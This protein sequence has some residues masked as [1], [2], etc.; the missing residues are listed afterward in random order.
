MGN[1]Q[2]RAQRVTDRMAD[3]SAAEVQGFTRLKRPPLGQAR[4]VPPS[5]ERRRA[6]H[7]GAQS[8]WRRRPHPRASDCCRWRFRGRGRRHRSRKRPGSALVRS[9][10]VRATTGCRRLQLLPPE[11][12]LGPWAVDAMAVRRLRPGARGRRDQH[13]RHRSA[14]VLNRRKG[15]SGLVRRDGDGSSK[16]GTVHG[17]ATAD[18]NDDRVGNGAD[19]MASASTCPTCPR[20]GGRG[21]QRPQP[22]CVQLCSERTRG[23]GPA[24]GAVR[25]GST[26]QI[27]VGAPLALAKPATKAADANSERPITCDMAPLLRRE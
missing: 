17:R 1:R 5:P 24:P 21:D 23:P 25:A 13:G 4:S 2:H 7:R 11:P 6:G 8:R 16:L 20:K 22:G 26:T 3:G 12:Q 15:V 14:A 9:R 27:R 19:F 18:S 10:P